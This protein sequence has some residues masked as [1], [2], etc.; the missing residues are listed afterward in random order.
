[1]PTRTRNGPP[2]IFP[3]LRYHDAAAAIDWL[4]RAFGFERL[5]VAPGP[6]ESIAHAQLACG[7]GVIM[8]SSVRD[9]DPLGLK[10]PRD[11]AGVSQGIYVHVDDVDAHHQLATAADAEIVF[12]LQDTDY[13][14]REY[15]ARDPEGYLWSFGTYRP[16]EEES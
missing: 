5:M 15:T 3:F 14:S 11:L 12:P 10:S 7:Q 6:D 8:L 2:D 13:G 16:G 4:E 1:M 9:D